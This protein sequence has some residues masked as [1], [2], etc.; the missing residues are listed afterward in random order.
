M[1]KHDLVEGGLHVEH[2]G[3]QPATVSRVDALHLKRSVAE[4]VNAEGLGQPAGR[5]NREYDDLAS[6]VGGPQRDGG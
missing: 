5:V 4:R 1:A 6:G 2:H 3:E